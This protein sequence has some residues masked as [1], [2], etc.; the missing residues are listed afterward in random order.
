MIFQNIGNSL[1]VEKK[2]HSRELGSSTNQLLETE[3][4]LLRVIKHGN[5]PSDT[6]GRNLHPIL[7]YYCFT[8]THKVMWA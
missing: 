5:L 7:Y 8:L 6:E 4:S 1:P 2:Q 3:I